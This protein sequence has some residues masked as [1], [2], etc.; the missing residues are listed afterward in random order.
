MMCALIFFAF[1]CE[2]PAARQ[3]VII[4]QDALGPGGS[5]MGSMLVLIQS[6]EIEVLG[7][8]IESGDGWQ[9]ENV[10]WIP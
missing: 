4:D 10:A 1:S 2:A 6:P 9:R 3:K 8:T 5:N 7:I